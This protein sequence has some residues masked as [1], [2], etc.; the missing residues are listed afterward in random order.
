M[1]FKGFFGGKV[2]GGGEG[3][4]VIL[5]MCAGKLGVGVEVR[6]GKRGFIGQRGD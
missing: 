3:L 1:G 6:K 4:P 5:G 2:L